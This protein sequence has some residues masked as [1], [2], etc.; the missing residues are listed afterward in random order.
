MM[1]RQRT[2]QLHK[3]LKQPPPVRVGNANGGIPHREGYELLIKMAHDLQ[4]YAPMLRGEFDGI[5]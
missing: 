2:I 1:A 5:A 4:S 3:R